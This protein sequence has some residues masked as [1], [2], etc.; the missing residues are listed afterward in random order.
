VSR[1]LRTFASLVHGRSR[2]VGLACHPHRTEGRK[3]RGEVAPDRRTD[4]FSNPAERQ[5]DAG[6]ELTVSG[7]GG[8]LNS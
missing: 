1:L 3:A 5:A 4:G 2:V 7:D 8:M 6:P